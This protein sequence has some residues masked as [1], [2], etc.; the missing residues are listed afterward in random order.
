MGMSGGWDYAEHQLLSAVAMNTRFAH[1]ARA[2][3]WRHCV[4]GGDAR[5]KLHN[6]SVEGAESRLSQGHSY[7]SLTTVN[8]IRAIMEAANRE[9]A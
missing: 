6:H 2:A 7:A 8:R 4:C 3:D 5:M 9:I 1:R